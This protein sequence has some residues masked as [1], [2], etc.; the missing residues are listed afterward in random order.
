MNRNV[1]D[2]NESLLHHAQSRSEISGLLQTD[3]GV[4]STVD[5]ENDGLLDVGNLRLDDETDE[6][7]PTFEVRKNVFE[8]TVSGFMNSNWKAYIQLMDLLDEME[9]PLV[10]FNHIMSWLHNNVMNGFNP[11]LKHP[12]RRTILEHLKKQTN[13]PPPLEKMIVLEKQTPRDDSLLDIVTDHLEGSVITF[14]F[15]SELLLLLLLLLQ[16][17]RSLDNILQ[18]GSIRNYGTRMQPRQ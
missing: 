17:T 4:G 16:C 3:D 7:N 1:V 2:E 13:V 15:K 12:S 5:D 14:D 10:A 9:C 18:H 11:R 8:S 6:M